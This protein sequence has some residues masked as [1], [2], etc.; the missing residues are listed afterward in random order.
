MIFWL[1]PSKQLEFCRLLVDLLKLIV[2]VIS[3]F[4]SESNHKVCLMS[5]RSQRLQKILLA[6]FLITYL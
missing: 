3:P 4:S 2:K 5:A 1:L 6:C